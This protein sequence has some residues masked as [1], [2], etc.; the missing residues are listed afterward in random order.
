MRGQ[1]RPA[2]TVI[3]DCDPGT[4]DA[5]A[6]LLALASPELDVAA[7]TVVGGNVPLARTL[8]NACGL[9]GLC[10]A[11]VPVHAG[12]ARALLA[13][14]PPG[15]AGHREDGMAGVAL[16]LGVAPA[17][18]SS[19]DAIRTILRQASRPVT[20][21][22]IGPATNL[23]LALATEPTLATKVEEIVLMSG[24]RGEGNATPGAEFNA[25]CDPEALAIVIGAERKLTLAPLESGRAVPVTAARLAA[26][27]N[28]GGGRAL[29]TASAILSALLSERPGGVPLYD[30]CAIAWLIAPA[31]FAAEPAAV[32]VDLGPGPSRGRTAIDRRGRANVHVLDPLDPDGLFALLAERIARLP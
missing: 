23:A 12:A 1:G 6:I 15:W 18:P 24:A 8:A 2:R 25:W 32:A 29:E 22:G 14:Y 27:R 28:A 21:V 10:G 5:I 19:A 7:I 31:L 13:P 16:P 4:D 3:L 26:F 9:V 17:P 11:E 20:L 30:P